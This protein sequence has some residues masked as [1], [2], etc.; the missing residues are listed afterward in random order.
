MSKQLILAVGAIL[1]SYAFGWVL[2]GVASP[3]KNYLTFCSGEG[4]A[5]TPVSWHNISCFNEG[6]K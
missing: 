4:P 5:G 2:I 6:A 3:L 1:A